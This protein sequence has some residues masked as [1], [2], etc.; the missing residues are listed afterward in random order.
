MRGYL[1]T[2][3]KLKRSRVMSTLE[4]AARIG[5]AFKRYLT[6]PVTFNGTLPSEAFGKE[7][8][9]RVIIGETYDFSNSEE[10]KVIGT[11]T[12]ATVIEPEKA[13][14]IAI[15][16]PDKG[17]HLLKYP[18]SDDELAD[19]WAH[20]EAYFGRIQP[21]SKGIRSIYEMFCWLMESYRNTPRERLLEFMAT[22]P[23]LD[24]LHKMS[25]DELRMH[26]CEGLCAT[27]EAE[28]LKKEQTASVASSAHSDVI[29]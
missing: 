17:S 16:T 20:P 2:E 9:K 6:F 18:L 11:V 24:E 12:S 28:R 29:S 27:L 7:P 21:V 25:D 10:E 14:Y 8:P 23:N 4:E 5:Q 3:L 13:A 22:A 1:V 19:Y 15:A 26:Y